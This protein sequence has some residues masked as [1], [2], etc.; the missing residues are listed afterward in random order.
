MKAL[1]A[2][3]FWTPNRGPYEAYPTKG[4]VDV[5]RK[6]EQGSVY[7]PMSVGACS[8][9]WTDTDDEGRRKLM[10]CF[11]TAMLHKDNLPLDVV[12]NAISQID[13]YAAFPFSVEKPYI[14]T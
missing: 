13:E 5:T 2:N 12:R 10:Q 6:P 7:H 1:E 14:E 9:D 4:T 11:V 3:V 8:C